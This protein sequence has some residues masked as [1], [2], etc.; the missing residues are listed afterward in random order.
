MVQAG[1]PTVEV[2]VVDWTGVLEGRVASSELKEAATR[3]AQAQPA[4]I[5]VD[6]RLSVPAPIVVEEE[7]EAPD[8][9]AEQA[10]LLLQAEI[11]SWTWD[12][13]RMRIA[14]ER[15]RVWASLAISAA[16]PVRRE[17]E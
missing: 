1:L 14:T 16:V 6:N 7:P 10:D 8:L 3:V 9:P 15:A 12:E 5:S 17:V 4:V 2:R 13:S 11:N